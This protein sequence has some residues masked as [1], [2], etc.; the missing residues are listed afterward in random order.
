LL[1]F[2]PFI[3]V[4]T[5]QNVRLDPFQQKLLNHVVCMVTTDA[6]GSYQGKVKPVSPVKSEKR[7]AKGKLVEVKKADDP[8]R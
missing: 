3:P 4:V 2:N 5:G 6:K 1:F 7:D 8:G